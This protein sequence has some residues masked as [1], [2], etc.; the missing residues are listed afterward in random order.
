MMMSPE[1]LLVVEKLAVMLLLA[2]ML[3]DIGLAD[4]E[5]SPDQLSKVYP[6]EALAAS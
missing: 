3:T 4:P 2:V 5:A 1:P 6:D